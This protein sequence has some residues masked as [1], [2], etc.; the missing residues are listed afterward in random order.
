ML[1]RMVFMSYPFLFSI[2]AIYFLPSIKTLPDHYLSLLPLFPYIAIAMGALLAW[3]FNR[4]RV[5]FS[6][7]LIFGLYVGLKWHAQVTGVS[8]RWLILAISLLL[9]LNLLLLSFFRERGIFTVHGGVRFAFLA[10]QVGVVWWL[11]SR[12]DH[13]WLSWLE[14]TWVSV[15][16]LVKWQQGVA[17][18]VWIVCALVVAWQLV[19]LLR[20]PCLVESSVLATLTMAMVAIALKTDTNGTA[21]LFGLAALLLVFSLVQESYG[22][23]YMDELT[24]LPGRRA[25]MANLM[26]LG[27]SYSIAMFDIDHFKK[28]NDTY[29]HDIGDQ[30]LRMVAGRIGQVTGGGKPARYGGEEFS[31]VFPRKS[32]ADVM[33]HL[34]MVRERIETTPFTIRGK[35][36]PRKAPKKKAARRSRKAMPAQKRV[37]VTVSIGVAERGEK[38]STPD[39]VMKAA[40][41]ALYRA[42]RKGRN[43]VCK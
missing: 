30:V 11:I 20:R 36:R 13:A 18:S 33:D 22:M 10:G 3:R 34:E 14:H 16:W 4:S 6:L 35:D 27:K 2:L 15:S 32:V 17:Q 40:D 26:S 41:K 37:T 31:V 28:F 24:G 9:P 5:F 43:Q 25:M 29:G 38:H 42:K 8:G 12:A 1:K 21:V 23:A 39:A 19:R 7:L